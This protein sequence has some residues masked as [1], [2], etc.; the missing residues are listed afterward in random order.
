MSEVS[1]NDLSEAKN[2]LVKIATHAIQ[3]K[4]LYAE[5]PK[6][7]DE[8]NKTIADVATKSK[9]ILKVIEKIKLAS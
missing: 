4:R 2:S 1:M 6:S 9:E 3:L 7:K 8:F 5:A